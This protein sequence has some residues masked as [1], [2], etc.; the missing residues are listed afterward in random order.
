MD[1][2]IF[3]KE[4]LK[5]LN[6]QKERLS[7]SMDRRVSKML[8]DEIVSIGA[9]TIMLYIPL[10]MEVDIMPLIKRLR[11]QKRVLFVPFMEGES[12]R[13]V[14]Y[15]LPLTK[16]QFGILEPKDSK[17]YRRREI[18]IAIVPMI[19]VDLLQRRIGFGKG[20]YDRFFEKEAKYIK[21]TIFISR[22]RCTSKRVLTDDY[23]IKAD[24]IITAFMRREY[25]I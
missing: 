1:K 19:G 3:R 5:R 25:K 10:G 13:L 15:R 17:Q 20:M 6:S 7:F 22:I 23:D 24:K 12:F 4:C 21:R 8:Y 18:D 16:K 14:K 11:K 2:N 9:K